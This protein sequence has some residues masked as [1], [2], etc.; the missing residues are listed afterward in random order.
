MKWIPAIAPPTNL[1]NVAG[2][3]FVSDRVLVSTKDGDFF[4][5]RYQKVPGI[6]AWWICQARLETIQ[7]VQKWTHIIKD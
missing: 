7:N 6:C 3:A 5:A 4:V 2:I 1:I